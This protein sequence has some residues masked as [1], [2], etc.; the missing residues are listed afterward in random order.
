MTTLQYIPHALAYHR[1]DD[2]DIIVPYFLGMKLLAERCEAPFGDASK[3]LKYMKELKTPHYK[4]FCEIALKHNDLWTPNNGVFVLM[5]EDEA[6]VGATLVCEHQ[7]DRICVRKDKEGKGY[8]KKMLREIP[9]RINEIVDK[10]PFHSPVA[11]HLVPLFK[12]C[13]WESVDDLDPF[14]Q[15]LLAWNE[16]PEDNIPEEKR[17]KVMFPPGMKDNYRTPSNPTEVLLITPEM[18]EVWWK[19][20]VRINLGV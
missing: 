10:F 5:D 16:R 7:L 9:A 15:Q 20:W 8:A 14:F 6:V 4:V 19:Q 3:L 11:H 17:M 18:R 12:S 2:R 1:T 13:G